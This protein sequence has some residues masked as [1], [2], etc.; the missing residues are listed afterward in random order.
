MYPYDQIM[1]TLIA[2]KKRYKDRFY[3][4]IYFDR[5]EMNLLP[6]GGSVQSFSFSYNQVL[7][8]YNNP[9]GEFEKAWKE[10]LKQYRKGDIND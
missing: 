3:F 8:W 10:K 9:I 1:K 7:K 5:I 6:Q 2:I 4:C